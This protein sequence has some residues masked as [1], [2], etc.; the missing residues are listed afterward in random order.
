MAA[1]KTK[2]TEYKTDEDITMM[3]DVLQDRENGRVITRLSVMR[4]TVIKN[5]FGTADAKAFSK[6]GQKS[7]D[8]FKAAMDTTMED[9][10][11]SHQRTFIELVTEASFLDDKIKPS[12]SYNK[13]SLCKLVASAD[14]IA[15][16]AGKMPKGI[17]TW[18]AMPWMMPAV[19]LW[20][21]LLMKFEGAA[22]H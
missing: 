17:Q 4:S 3:T 7:E 14:N 5:A 11:L 12:D 15:I 22:E 19:Q 1:F 10:L 16:R 21:N 2:W 6:A 9:N 18:E 20:F 8:G 13:E